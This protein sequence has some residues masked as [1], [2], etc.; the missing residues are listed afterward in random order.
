MVQW[1]IEYEYYALDRLGRCRWSMQDLSHKNR[2]GGRRPRPPCP[3]L[4]RILHLLDVKEIEDCRQSYRR[5]RMMDRWSRRMAR[6][7][8]RRD[9]LTGV[10]ATEATH[11]EQKSKEQKRFP[12]ASSRNCMVKVLEL[13]ALRNRNGEI[14]VGDNRLTSRSAREKR[15]LR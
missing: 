14:E 15:L 13:D 7:K 2:P 5:L 3:L 8:P 4:T 6:N 12:M 9:L 11:A 10:R 1:H